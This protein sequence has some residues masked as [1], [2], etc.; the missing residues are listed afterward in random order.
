MPVVAFAFASQVFGTSRLAST[1]R[2]SDRRG[3]C[4]PWL[5]DYGML[6]K[7]QCSDRPGYR[8]RG[9]EAIALAIMAEAQACCTGKQIDARRLSVEQVHSCLADDSSKMYLQ[10]QCG[11]S[12]A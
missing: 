11:L 10:T 4:D 5:V 7:N 8:W 12:L 9:P 1:Q 6:R 3:G 2:T